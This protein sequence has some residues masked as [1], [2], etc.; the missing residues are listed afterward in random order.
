MCIYDVLA[1]IY[2]T[3]VNPPEQ[4]FTQEAAPGYGCDEH[5]TRDIGHTNNN[6]HPLPQPQQNSGGKRH[7]LFFNPSLLTSIYKI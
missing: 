3:K 1:T 7:V 2:L 5:V 4:Y 6:H